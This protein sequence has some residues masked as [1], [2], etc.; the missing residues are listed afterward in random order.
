M[1]DIIEHLQQLGFGQYETQAYVALLKDNPANGYEL[2]KQSVIPRPSIYSV[3][4]KLENQGIVRRVETPNGTRYAPLPH[5]ELISRLNHQFQGVIEAASISLS[6]IAA[7]ATVE[8]AQNFRGYPGLLDY[9]RRMLETTRSHLLVVTWP[10]EA[11][12]LAEPLQQARQRDIHLTTLCLRGCERPCSYCQGNIFRFRLVPITQ[13]ARWLVLVADRAEML[14]G[15]IIPGQDTLAV[16]TRQRML[17]DLAIGYIQNSIALARILSGL[18]DLFDNLLD[19]ETQADLDLLQSQDH[20]FDSM[21]QV[22][23]APENPRKLTNF[24]HG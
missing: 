19:S 18:G 24:E 1:I 21:R 3:L 7:P 6:E 10:E 22:I 11:R 12:A 4:Q 16:S 13:Q 5:Q 9:S 20:W 17:V 15:E 14:A 2:A 8:Y 23:Y